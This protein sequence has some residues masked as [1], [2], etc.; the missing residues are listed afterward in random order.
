M[1]PKTYRTL[2]LDKILGR[3]AG[4]AD[5]SA[6]R[7]LLEALEP[8]N[9]LDEALQRQQETTEACRFLE[10]RNAVSI[11][12]AR[13]VRPYVYDATVGVTLSPEHLLD[14]KATLLSAGIL[15]KAIDKAADQFPLLSEIALGMDEGK[16]LVS[17]ISR[18]IGD[19]GEVLDSASPRL[20]QLRGEIRVARD[21]LQTKLQSIIASSRNAPYLQEALIT[22]R[23]GRYVIPIKSEHKGRI[24]GIVHDQSASGATLF[25]EP[26]ATVE[27]NN[28]I[29]ELEL[30]EEE[31]VRRLLAE[32]TAE[33]GQQA[34]RITWTVEA[35]AALDAAFAKAKYA[36]ELNANPPKLVGFDPKRVPGSTLKIYGARHPLIDP[37]EVVPIDVDLDEDT[38]VL[39]ITG[40]NTGG[41]TVSLKTVGLMVLMAQCGL[42]VPATDAILTVFDTVYADIGDEQSIEQSLSTFSSHLVTIVDILEHADDRSL[43]LF[44]EL[45]SGTDPAEGSAIA[46]AILNDLLQRG[47]TTFV[48]T[49]YPELKAYAHGTPGVRN[50][51][52]EFDIET[53]SPT[54]RLIV[55]LPGKSNALAIATRLGLPHSI[56]EAAKAYVGEADLKTDSLLEEIHRTREE[57]RQAQ[58]RLSDTE[59][60][61]VDLRSQLQERLAGIEEER[62]EIIEQARQEAHNELVDMQNEIATLRRRLRSVLPSR[63]PEGPHPA[64]EIKEIEEEVEVLEELLDDPVKRAAVPAPAPKAARPAT[65]RELRVGDRVFVASLNAKGEIVTL[66]SDEIEVQVGAMR[67]R[68]DRHD[69]ERME[70]PQEEEDASDGDALARRYTQEEASLPLAESPG[71]ELHLIGYNVDEASDALDQYLDRAYRAGLPWVRIVHGKGSGILRKAIRDSL[72]HHPLVTDFKRAAD[73]EGGD[74][75]TV[76][77]L[78]GG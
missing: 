19:Q 69:L 59:N 60:E 32:L 29:R 17:A 37:R 18:V 24:K 34:D 64:G 71:L 6:S 54:Y 51:S 50:A 33:I 49:H 62:R 36:A 7:A 39:V 22:S 56:I 78:I 65:R 63:A 15:K 55:G 43:V 28:Q 12:G 57:I 72:R 76:A 5:F 67:V 1:T 26:L 48:A 21:R 11:G 8:T 68:V 42:H 9:D 75:A 47:I 45:G 41:K 10:G 4:Y 73:N 16:A 23:S 40:P 52:V 35:I 30:K 74:G 70:Q 13:D 20:G 31:E 3:L 27:T 58:A 44:D 61:S 14:I 53:L 2:E 66:G 25:I 46:R 38:Y 77:T